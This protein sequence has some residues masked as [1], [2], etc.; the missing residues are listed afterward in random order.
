MEIN[1]KEISKIKPHKDFEF[2]LIIMEL[3]IK[4]FGQVIYNKVKEKNN[5]LMVLI[6]KEIFMKD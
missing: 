6:M 2:I 1:Y 3:Y 5:F 4:D